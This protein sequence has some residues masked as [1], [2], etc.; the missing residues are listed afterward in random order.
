MPLNLYLQPPSGVKIIYDID[1]AWLTRS[2]KSIPSVVHKALAEI[3]HSHI[4]YRGMIV[5]GITGA[6]VGLNFCSTG[7]KAIWLLA[8]TQ[9]VVSISECG[10]NARDFIF[11][12]FKSG[13]VLFKKPPGGTTL[14]GLSIGHGAVDVLFEGIHITTVP[15]LSELLEDGGMLCGP[16]HYTAY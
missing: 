6:E 8:L 4:N 5:S 1:G 14:P 15:A 11:S 9:S 3:D 7:V 13:S 12:N 2:D 16:D 10:Q